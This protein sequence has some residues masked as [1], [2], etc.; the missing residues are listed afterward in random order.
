MGVSQ[1]NSFGDEWGRVTGDARSGCKR[2][3]REGEKAMTPHRCFRPPRFFHIVMTL[4]VLSALALLAAAQQTPKADA[5]TGRVI[6]EDGN[7]IVSAG[8][9]AYE[10]EGRRVN[11][12][13]NGTT[14]DDEG[15]FRLTGLPP[16]MYHLSAS[17]VGYLSASVYASERPNQP[18]DLYFQPGAS[19]T[20]TL[21]KGGVITGRVTNAQDRAVVTVPVGLEYA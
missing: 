17:A 2:F 11:R 6:G 18:D 10:V 20:I 3:K 1:T 4:S 5:I 12:I 9:S 15:Y 14:T 13:P 21:K 16:G 8:V 7:P 19:V